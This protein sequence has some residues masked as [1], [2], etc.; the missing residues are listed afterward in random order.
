MKIMSL[1]PIKYEAD[2]GF[3]SVNISFQEASYDVVSFKGRPRKTQKIVDNVFKDFINNIGED[4]GEKVRNIM[5]NPKS[6]NIFTATLVSLAVSVTELIMQKEDIEQNTIPIESKQNKSSKKEVKN[7]Q[8]QETN[9]LPKRKRI[10]SQMGEDALIAKLQD[11]ANR[12]YTLAQMSAELD[13]L[14]IS[15]ISKYMKKYNITKQK[16]KNT[17]VQKQN[18]KKAGKADKYE[19][20]IQDSQR[21]ANLDRLKAF[22]K[23]NEK[24]QFVLK[25]YAVNN[26][27][28]ENKQ[29]L[30]GIE[31]VL[32][33]LEGFP[34]RFAKQY[35]ELFETKYA[36]YFDKLGII[37]NNIPQNQNVQEFLSELKEMEYS[38]E[39]INQRLQY[40][41]LQFREIK[42]IE[43][44]P[45]KSKI[46]INEV[47]S[48]YNFKIELKKDDIRHNYG[49]ILHFT[50]SNKNLSD[51]LKIISRFHEALYDNIYLHKDTGNKVQRIIDIQDELQKLV[52]KDK[53]WDSVYNTVKYL[54]PEEFINFDYEQ[55]KND[56]KVMNEKLEDA[57]K[58]INI[59]TFE[60]IEL[61]N[62]INDNEIFDGLMSNNHAKIRF[63]SRFVLNKDFED[64]DLF[65]AANEAI[66]ELKEDLTEKLDNGC[67]VFPYEMNE[68][69][70]PS[71][72]LAKSKL[73]DYIRVTLNNQ[74]EIHTIYED[75]KK[76]SRKY[77]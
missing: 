74:G 72:Y 23:L 11:M 18:N 51:K 46:A 64:E 25:A 15:S 75:N 5:S 65:T 36:E 55:N 50:E 60:A 68:S 43:E 8:Q 6:K 57:I 47:K 24:Y 13:G 39:D 48:Q 29:A 17:D 35:L 61:E 69:N 38:E 42:I 76:K 14:G 27:D 41:A 77:Y 9:I 37:A 22:P 21:K 54:V 67:Y 49:F 16:N 31:K 30:E 62:L 63:I 44:L 33:V 71:F 19:I 34:A 26:N 56:S 70:A 73:G 2:Y 20:L 32:A 3:K 4:L 53:N 66:N 1:T 59:H 45:Q 52:K 10:V 28:N 12:G 40:P 58:K 7:T